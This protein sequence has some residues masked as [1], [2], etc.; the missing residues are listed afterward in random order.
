MHVI[1]IIACLGFPPGL[2]T[3][4]KW[5]GFFQSGK[6]QGILNRLEKSSKMTKNTGKHCVF[7][8]NVICH[9][10]GDI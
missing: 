4:E 1:S 2:E 5:E 6:S 8:G 10:F 3:L 7:Q 9:F